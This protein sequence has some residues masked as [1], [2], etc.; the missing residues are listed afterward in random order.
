MMKKLAILVGGLVI[1]LVAV[2]AVVFV[3]IDAIARA[4][5][6]RGSTYALGVPTTL[7]SAN[8]G[9]LSGEFTMKDLDVANPD[10]FDGDYFFQLDEGFVA[11]SLG[12][13]RQD[14]VEIPTLTLTGVR[15]NLQKKG[16]RAN[17]T[18]IT[19]N[20]KR[21]ESGE[22]AGE[23]RNRA[24]EDGERGKNFM[25]HE[26]VIRD[27]HVTVDVLP[28]GGELTRIEIP[29]EEVRLT[30][31]GSETLTTAEVTSRVIKMILAAV[32]KNGAKL[33]ADLVDDLGGALRGL[34]DL[35]NIDISQIADI[36]G[37]A[38]TIGKKIETVGKSVDDA[39]KGLGGL[40]G[41][42]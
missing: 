25:I 26:I 29:I 27:V 22:T 36:A 8:I 18:V 9:I 23:E 42:K 37:T 11:V 6:E 28:I 12:S 15:M 5:I 34:A 2:V 38:D 24:E 16:G 31:I 10:G 4:A 40:L 3:S 39:L 1:L 14:T 19:E 35:G 20:L 21:L 32:V 30:E 41:D 33:P 13:L 7:G 17:Y